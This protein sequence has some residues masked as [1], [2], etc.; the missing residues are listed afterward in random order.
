MKRIVQKYGG[1][2]VG[3]IERLES[4]AKRIKGYHDDNCQVV[5]VVSAMA[6]TTDE[7]VGLAHKV[8]P[9]PSDREMDMLLATGEQQSVA[10]LAMALHGLG[11]PAE[12]FTG[13]QAGIE[14]D[15][16]HCK[17]RVRNVDPARIEQ[18]L[19]QGNVVVVAGFQGRS[20]EDVITTLGRG[21]SDLTA[22]ALS[23][24]L[25]AD[26]CRIY[27]DV[28]GVYTADPRIVS[29]ARKLDKVSH[30]E[31]LEMAS[32]GTKV[33]QARS[34]EF[35]KNFDLDLEVRSSEKDIPGTLI[36]RETK[37]MEDSAVHG[38]SVDKKEAKLRI[39]RV[40]DKPGR[41]AR[42]FEML[43]DAGI[44]VDLIVQN[45]SEQGYTDISCT[46][47][48]AELPKVEGELAQKIKNDLETGDIT[49]DQ[50][51]AK[52]SVVGVGMRTHCGIAA[53]A[54][55]ALAEADVNI[56]MIATSEIKISCVLPLENADR[57]VQTL[58]RA[59]ELDQA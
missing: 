30:E 52:V 38:V 24:A 14:T 15:G 47:P 9:T 22:V 28:D 25:H 55:Q 48:E 8:H 13:A 29:D 58:H 33:M 17:A 26:L 20:S 16:V 46:V 18:S 54:F 36:T 34:I 3:D 51:I 56:E 59:F 4:V 49:W 2:S 7:L 1:S 27:S 53:K 37:D 41:A 43:A 40:P 57:A 35:A 5:V 19:E 21:G 12:S 39:S 23:A 42:L 45:I 50:D 6:G 32:L 10:L 31:M 44:N 11:C